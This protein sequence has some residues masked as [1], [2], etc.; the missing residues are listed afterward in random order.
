MIVRRRPVSTGVHP[1][2]VTDFDSPLRGTQAP[3]DRVAALPA[4]RWFRDEI[5]YILEHSESAVAVTDAEHAGDVESLVGTVAWLK[6][7]VVAPGER[8]DRLTASSPTRLVG[9]RP[10]DPAWLFYTGGTTHVLPE[11]RH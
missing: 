9:R 5:A 11:Y 10:E 3:R 8:W 7:A 4:L 2:G 1:C 6:A